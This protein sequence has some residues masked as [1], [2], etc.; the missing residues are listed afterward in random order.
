CASQSYSDNW[1]NWYF[2]LW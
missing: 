1:L 2:D